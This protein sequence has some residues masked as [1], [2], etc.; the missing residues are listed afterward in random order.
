MGRG[1]KPILGGEMKALEYGPLHSEVYDLL[2]QETSLPLWSRTFERYAGY[3][4]R[5]RDGADPGRSNLSPFEVEIL[6][7]WASWARG[8]GF[9]EITDFT[10]EFGEWR[11]AYADDG[12]SHP[13]TAEGLLRAV[14]F[15]AEDAAEAVREQRAH[16]EFLQA[17]AS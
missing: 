12:S 14:G 4:T 13:I 16:D 2:R 1:G 3:H 6:E 15:S 11:D 17:L 8:R 7:K 9:R 5:I 10:H